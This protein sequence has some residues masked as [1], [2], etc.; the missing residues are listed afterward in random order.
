MELGWV[1]LGLKRA[2]QDAELAVTVV[3][4]CAKGTVTS[5]PKAYC[6]KYT[7]LI[8]WRE[9]TC[10]LHA[11][12]GS[13]KQSLMHYFGKSFQVYKKPIRKIRYPFHLW[14]C[15]CFMEVSEKAQACCMIIHIH[16]QKYMFST[17]LRRE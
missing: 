14:K 3:V 13:M 9:M 17:G 12:D 6:E 2:Q 11:L 5:Y 8:L 15:F 16:L 10:T 1:I 4:A 7:F